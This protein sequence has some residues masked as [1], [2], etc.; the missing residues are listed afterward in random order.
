MPS[1]EERGSKAASGVNA[2]AAAAGAVAGIATAAGAV[3]AV[4]IAGQVI[5]AALAIAAVLTKIFAGKGHNAKR[6]QRRDAQQAFVKASRQNTMAYR[7]PTPQQNAV[8]PQQAPPSQGSGAFQ[9]SQAGNVQAP[10]YQSP[11]TAQGNL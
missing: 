7:P 6:R 11:G 3:Q 4:P 9:Q 2:G 5:G 1:A 10:I 8:A